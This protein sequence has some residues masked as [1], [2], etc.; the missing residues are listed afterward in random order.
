MSTLPTSGLA[1]HDRLRD[2]GDH[3]RRD[4]AV[5]AETAVAAAYPVADAVDPD[6]QLLA[7]PAGTDDEAW[8]GSRP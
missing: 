6:R 2:R 4:P 7:D 5:E 8:T 1:G 3:A